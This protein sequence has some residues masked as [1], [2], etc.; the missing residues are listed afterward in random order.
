LILQVPY[1]YLVSETQEYVKNICKKYH[2]TDKYHSSYLCPVA[3]LLYEKRERNSVFKNWLSLIPSNFDEHPLMLKES[4]LLLLNNTFSLERIREGKAYMDKIVSY[5][6]QRLD[7]IKIEEEIKIAFLNVLTRTFSCGKNDTP[8][9]S[10]FSDL[11]NSNTNEN[12][13]MIWD[14]DSKSGD[15]IIHAAR[16]VKK[17][18]EL[19]DSY[20]S[21][22]S[23]T[24]FFE[25]WG[26]TLNQSSKKFLGDC[27][28]TFNGRKCSI[29]LVFPANMEITEKENF[30]QCINNINEKTE[31]LKFIKDDLQK[32][33]NSFKSTVEVNFNRKFNN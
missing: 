29:K 28:F 24:N 8:T 32:R 18:E 21:E 11:F 14:F 3:F 33:Y 31:L 1:K 5:L 15:Q 25:N 10:P 23:N 19:F 6:I 30:N 12:I 17:G 20:L 13:N 16:D 27:A 9:M 7:F 4:D 22:W 26:M 2:I